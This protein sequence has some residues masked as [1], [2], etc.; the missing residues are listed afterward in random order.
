MWCG[1]RSGGSSCSSGNWSLFILFC[2][3]SFCINKLNV[4]HLLRW[5]NQK[6]FCSIVMHYWL[7]CKNY[8]GIFIRVLVLIGIWI[9]SSCGDTLV[10]DSSTCGDTLVEIWNNIACSDTLVHIGCSCNLVNIPGIRVIRTEASSLQLFRCVSIYFNHCCWG[11][12]SAYDVT[13]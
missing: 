6:K 5:I 11:S 8:H 7:S 2:G 13:V 1:W 9:N 10:D 4:S 12:C 3:H